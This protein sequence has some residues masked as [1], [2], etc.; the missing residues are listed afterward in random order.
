MA[1]RTEV[2]NQ[3]RK[4]YFCN[5]AN[6]AR[7]LSGLGRPLG[8]SLWEKREANGAGWANGRVGRKVGRA[9]SEEKNF[10]IKKI[11]FLNLLRL[12]KFAHGDLEEFWHEDFS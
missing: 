5:Y 11:E 10:W 4:T 3:R 2:V 12:W 7:G 9:E 6:G 8:F 1:P